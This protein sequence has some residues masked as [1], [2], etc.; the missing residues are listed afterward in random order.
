[1]LSNYQTLNTFLKTIKCASPFHPGSTPL[2]TNP[3][4]CYTEYIP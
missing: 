4:M 2:F 1:M 3:G